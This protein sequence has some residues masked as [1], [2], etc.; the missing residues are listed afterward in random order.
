MIIGKKDPKFYGGFSSEFA[1]KGLSLN[2][3]F[4]YS[5]GGKAVS[6]YYEG[7]MSGTGYGSAH[8]D[9]LDRW[10]PTHTDTNIPRA[11]YDNGARFSSGE[12]SWGIQNSSFLRLSTLTLAYNFPKVITQKIGFSNLRVYASGT[13]LLLVT[14][15]KGYDP[16][17]G[18]A[19][20]TAKSLVFGLNFGF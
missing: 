4:T 17:N 5:Y 8:T 13:N 11:T 1:W 12:T 3:V 9:M 19:Y 15:Y 6:G 10:T 20:P 7:L 2:T 18:D 14:K 16:E